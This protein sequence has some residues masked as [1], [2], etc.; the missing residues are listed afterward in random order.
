MSKTGV[1]FHPLHKTTRG[2]VVG[3]KFAS[4]PEIL[5]GVLASD[6]VVLYRPEPPPEELLL[7]VHTP[8]VIENLKRQYYG[9]A[10]LVT[11]GGCVRAAELVWEGEITNA[12]VFNIAAGH[13]AGTDYAWGGTYVSCT[14]PAIVN[15]RQKSPARRFAILDT[16]AHHGDGCR[17][18]F[19]EDREVLHVCFC[20]REYGDDRHNV[21]VEV[22]WS[23]DDHEYLS[24]VDQ[25]FGP[26][27]REFRP[28]VIFHFLGHDI[29]QGDYG[30]LGL[31]EGFF[32]EL[33]RLVKTY[34][35][36]VCGGRYV[37][38]TG[39]GACREVAEYIFPRIIQVLAEIREL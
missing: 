18:I 11:V 39:G 32:V 7:K 25:E 24:L 14:G 2:P 36:Q 28:E 37:V 12:L 9:P 4:F 6:R 19:Q 5:E 30:S 15:L 22:G 31:S 3:G 26:R 21:D 13:H 34:A 29:C 38:I 17:E 16:D 35:D 33:V 20:G 10:A 8:G 23:V 1:F 27:V